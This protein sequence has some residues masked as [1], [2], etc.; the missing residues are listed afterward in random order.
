[1]NSKQLANILVK[2]VG[3][4]I[5]AHAVPTLA[6]LFCAQMQQAAVISGS[7]LGVSTYRN[8]V[9]TGSWLTGVSPV[10][11]VVL[12]IV[13]IFASRAVSNWLFSMEAPE[14]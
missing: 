11:G 10:S 8:A 9:L 5:C 13:L 1:M 3:L 14:T 6:A 2:I 12:G 4:E 7:S